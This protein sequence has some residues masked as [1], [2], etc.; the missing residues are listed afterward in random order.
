MSERRTNADLLH[1]QACVITSPY[2]S[3]R[4]RSN[5]AANG[6][7]KAT[8]VQRRSEPLGNVIEAPATHLHK[9][10]MNSKTEGRLTWL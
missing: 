4:S 8:A 1:R 3:A 2:T 6:S 5:C 7:A 10:C 9:L